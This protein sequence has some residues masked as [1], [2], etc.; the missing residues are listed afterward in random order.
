MSG[1]AI[2]SKGVDTL[3]ERLKN[4]GVAAGA[5]EAARI[6]ADAKAEAAT[7]VAEAKAEAA[8][9]QSDV[10]K[11][12][13]QYRAAGE[14]ALK[15]AM[16]DAVLTMKAGLM[17]QFEADVKR[18]V[19]TATADPDLLRRMVIELVGRARDAAGAGADTEVIVPSEAVRSEHVVDNPE[20]VRSG[21]LTEFVLGLSAA[22]LEEG[23][24]LFAADDLHGGV[25]ARVTGRDMEIDLSD[26]AIAA[27]LM[28]HLQPRFRAV[29]EGVIR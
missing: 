17:A 22:M 1:S 8:R 24:V 15:T 4:E 12:A 6:L 23:V 13:D 21:R 25:R 19:S 20:L 3:I 9:H 7:I 16:R 29:M 26:E 2:T 5:A 10:R 27:L 18:L 14:E 11:S 28:R